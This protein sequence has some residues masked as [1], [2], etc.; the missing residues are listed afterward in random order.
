METEQTDTEIKTP[1][2]LVRDNRDYVLKTKP[3]KDGCYAFCIPGEDFWYID[4]ED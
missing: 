3:D 2:P 4:F 1:A